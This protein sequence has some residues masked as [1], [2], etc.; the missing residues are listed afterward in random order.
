RGFT[1]ETADV[2]LLDLGTSFGLAVGAEGG[3]DLV[4]F[5]GEVRAT[6]SDGEE[7]TLLGG[8]S[9]HFDGQEKADVASVAREAFPDIS[10]VFA[11]AGDR[12]EAELARWTEA[13]LDLRRDPRL[14]AYYDFENLTL[15]S[16]RLRNRAP[17]D[18]A[19]ELDGG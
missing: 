2:S 19:S 18:F 14:V 12:A 8:D 1:I 13:S 16:R 9:A 17:G 5:D 15:E 4:V 11:G 6:G 10:E 7:V 3:A